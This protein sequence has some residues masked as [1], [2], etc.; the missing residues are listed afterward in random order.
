MLR[1]YLFEIA[2]LPLSTQFA[3]IDCAC[4]RALHS[5]SLKPIFR[6]TW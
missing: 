1:C 3:A 2:P 4:L 6:V 5:S